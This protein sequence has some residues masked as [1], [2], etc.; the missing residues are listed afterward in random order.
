M[1]LV[2]GGLGTGKKEFVLHE[3]GFDPEGEDVLCAL[4]TMNPLPPVEELL[5]YRVVICR[6]VGCGVVPVDREERERREA[7][8]RLCCQLARQAEAV[9]RVACGLGMRLK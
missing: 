4:Q 9:W 8:G 7:L 6:E 1:I 3:L 5:R 2:I